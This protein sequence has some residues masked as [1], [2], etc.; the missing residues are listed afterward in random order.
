MQTS[1]ETGGARFLEL[2][3]FYDIRQVDVR[4]QQRRTAC[5]FTT[6]PLTQS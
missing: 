6:E 3:Q 2:R 4:V 5:I 1:I